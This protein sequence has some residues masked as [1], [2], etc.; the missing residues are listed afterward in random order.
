MP[1]SLLEVLLHL[2]CVKCTVLFKGIIHG[3]HLALFILFQVRVNMNVCDPKVK[4]T[5]CKGCISV[6]FESWDY[7]S[8]FPF[9]FMILFY[10]L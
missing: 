8:V 1:L 9:H 2:R 3:L 6:N 7:C 10:Q 5:I 4:F